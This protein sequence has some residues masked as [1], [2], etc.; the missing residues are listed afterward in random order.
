MFSADYQ[1]AE[2]LPANVS[3]IIYFPLF[4]CFFLPAYY[5]S[6]LIEYNLAPDK[7]SIFVSVSDFGRSE[8]QRSAK[9]Q[10]PE[11]KNCE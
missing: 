3:H 5:S 8:K 1:E 6:L 9:E 4:L 11:S 10:N 2:L 7:Y